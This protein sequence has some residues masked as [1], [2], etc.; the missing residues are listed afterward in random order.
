MVRK[1][2]VFVM[3]FVWMAVALAGVLSAAEKQTGDPL[4]YAGS[5]ACR[6]CHAAEFDSWKGTWH[7]KMVMKRDEGILKDAVEKWA[8]DGANPGPE[9]ANVT[10]RRISVLDVEYVV[11]SYWKQRYLVRNETTGNLQFANKQFNRMSGKWE[12][13]GQKNDWE[14]MCATC[15]TTG[16]RLVKYDPA[17]PKSQKAEWTELGIGC[18]SCH[19]PGAKHVKSLSKKDI[20]N[21]AGKKAAEQ[22]RVCGYCHIRLDNEMYR[23]A[24]GNTREDFPAPKVGQSFKPSD[25]WTKWYP[26][27]VIIPGVQPE[28]RIDA[29]Y[30]GDLKGMFL[31]DN[32]AKEA[33]VYEATKHHQEYQEWLQ[34]SHHKGGEMSC[35]TC[36]SPH[37]GKK[38]ARKDPRA[39]CSKCHDASYT[40][41]KYMPGTGRTADNLYVRSHTFRKGQSRPGGPTVSGTPEYYF[42]MK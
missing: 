37:A 4:G 22:S 28:D 2:P 12:N 31:L 19:G 30:K 42:K 16:Y 17:D 8:T 14:T 35:L 18:E 21:F 15:H 34:S 10:G 24:Q 36:H 11:G 27:H 9:K 40:V 25:D 3:V 38:T 26:D 5:D 39:S 20:W 6:K 29:E 1:I 7:A 41:E 23:S 32:V 33:G 13:Y